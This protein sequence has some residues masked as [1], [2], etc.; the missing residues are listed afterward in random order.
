MKI[1]L[2]DDHGIMRAGVRTLI[3]HAY[4]H[5]EII[6]AGHAEQA[7]QLA[8]GHRPDLIFLDLIIPQHAGAI[9]S[10]EIGLNTL[11]QLRESELIA[12][13]VVMSG[14]KSRDIVD[15]VLMRG[16]SSF[17]PKTASQ[18][19]MFEA[20]RRAL[21][22]G[23]YLPGDEHAG[24][25]DGQSDAGLSE[26]V[27]PPMLGITPR[28]FDV[29]RLALQGNPPWKIALI[30]GINATNVRRYLSKMYEK[31]GVIDLCGL[32]GHFAKTG[33]VF[34]IVSASSTNALAAR[35]AQMAS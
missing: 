30:L 20:I 25:T 16:A 7:I 1:L 5:A 8:D 28:E 6:E 3:L 10:V 34:G 12:P 22:G 33:Q 4:P 24:I 19:V 26:P 31:F 21:G 35:P 11:T 9:E 17:V 13:V 14:D 2:V 29:L 23:V 27:T 18:E 32:Q 15:M